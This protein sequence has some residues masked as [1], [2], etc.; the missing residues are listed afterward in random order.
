MGCGGDMRG[1]LEAALRETVDA[2]RQ[3]ID[4]M[5]QQLL[6]ARDEMISQGKEIQA[7]R[8]ALGRQTRT[9]DEL[10]EEI[11]RLEQYGQQLAAQYSPPEQVI[12]RGS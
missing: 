10:R 6:T 11:E 7:L 4:V 3:T 9:T 8:S 1:V 2:Q 12:E 5:Q